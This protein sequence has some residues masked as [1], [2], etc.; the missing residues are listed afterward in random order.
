MANDVFGAFP[1]SRTLLTL[2][3]FSSLLALALG[4]PSSLIHYKSSTI[5]KIRAINTIYGTRRPSN[6]SLIVSTDCGFVEGSIFFA[7]FSSFP[8]PYSLVFL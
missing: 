2:F 8:S 1:R 6:E 7:P 3:L 4:A 5:E